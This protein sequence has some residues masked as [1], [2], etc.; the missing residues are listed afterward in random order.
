MLE[1]TAKPYYC[2]A[3]EWME[4]KNNI[5]YHS[6]MNL[7]FLYFPSEKYRNPHYG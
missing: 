6:D 4:I 1:F 2:N 7:I 3:N 5:D